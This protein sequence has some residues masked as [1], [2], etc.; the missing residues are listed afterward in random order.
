[1]VKFHEKTR[2]FMKFGPFFWSENGKITIFSH[3]WP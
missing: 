3:F 1:M 2:F